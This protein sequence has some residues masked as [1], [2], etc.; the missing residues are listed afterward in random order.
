MTT[1]LHTNTSMF[2]H[3]HSLIW[4]LENP[5]LITPPFCKYIKLIYFFIHI[6]YILS[7][8]TFCDFHTQF[9]E[10]L[11]VIWWD[12]MLTKGNPIIYRKIC[13]FMT[14]TQLV[15]RTWYVKS[16]ANSNSVSGYNLHACDMTWLSFEL[17]SC[18][19]VGFKDKCVTINFFDLFL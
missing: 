17:R 6:K 8:L 1:S 2:M 15:I 14:I 18:F 16:L 4:I 3:I 11:F 13:L 12:P 19:C 7:I 5:K 9:S 10:V